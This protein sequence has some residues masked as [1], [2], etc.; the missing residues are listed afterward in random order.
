MKIFA[1]V[2]QSPIAESVWQHA[3]W[4]ANQLGLPVEIIHVLDQPASTSTRDFSG[5]HWLENSQ[6]AMEQRVQLD[7]LQNRVVISEGRQLL[8]A[9]AGKVREAGV[10]QVSQR[11]FQGTLLD[12]LRDH[13]NDCLIA[14]IG[15]RGEGASRDRQHLGS[16][17]ERLVRSAHR[18]ILIAAPE[19]TPIERA[20]IAWD[21]GASSGKSINLL[22]NRP[23]LHG[24]PTSILHI[25][26]HPEKLPASLQDVQAHLEASG[27]EVR[28]TGRSGP[29]ADAILQ[30]VAED[31]SQ[32]LVIG[33]YGHSRIRQLVIGSTTTEILMRS[34]TSVLVFH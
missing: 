1:Y 26:E 27:M 10:E 2:D 3:V 11:L 15:K 12:H 22:A 18:P 23:L 24:T 29:V 21:G 17:V 8:D 28:V 19:F 30:A 14:V 32:L 9:V 31:S 13:A 4:V 6:R 5:H 7:E 25:T 16:N 33:A 34:E 20:T